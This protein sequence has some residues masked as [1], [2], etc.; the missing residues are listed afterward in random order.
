LAKEIARVRYRTIQRV[1][2]FVTLLGLA[3]YLGC[4]APKPCTVSP[5]QIEEIAA[6][7]R[8]INVTLGEKK[9][10]LASLES[11]IAELEATIAQ[12]SAEIPVKQAEL[13]RLKK[14][15]GRTE[16]PEPEKTA[17]GSGS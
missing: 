9:T 17:S 8:D 2:L 15:S 7:I 12:R 14:A 6:D 10:A 4:S 11:E 16:K 13:A 3:A 1:V 5:V